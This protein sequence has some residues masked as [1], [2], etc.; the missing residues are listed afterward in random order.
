MSAAQP[1]YGVFW[2]LGFGCALGFLFSYV[3]Y[4][5]QIFCF[6]LRI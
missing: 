3:L 2:D 5:S 1:A 4:H 6:S